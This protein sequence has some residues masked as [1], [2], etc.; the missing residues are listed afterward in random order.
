MGGWSL[1]LDDLDDVFIVEDV[2]FTAPLG[3]V[4]DTGAPNLGAAELLGERLVDSVV[5]LHSTPCCSVS[6]TDIH[7]L[8]VV[9]EAS[10]LSVYQRC[11]SQC[12]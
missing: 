1:F 8:L 2:G 6:S 3:V 12:R 10:R 4:F 9:G 11:N 5:A 7:F